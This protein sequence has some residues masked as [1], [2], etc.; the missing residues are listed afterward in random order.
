[1]GGMDV[2]SLK[3]P[4]IAYNTPSLRNAWAYGAYLH[5]G[6]RSSIRELLTLGNQGDK[7][8]TTS[9]L[10]SQEIQALEAYIKSL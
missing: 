1:M 8:G 10:K 7:M 9:H 4:P 6:S 5:D 3:E 2:A